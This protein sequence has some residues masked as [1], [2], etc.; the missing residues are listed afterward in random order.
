MANVSQQFMDD[1]GPL[2][3]LW[4]GRDQGLQENTSQ[5]NQQVGLENIANSQQSRDIAKQK[6]PFE[7]GQL[8]HQQQMNPL[9]IQEKEGKIKSDKVKLDKEQFDN[10]FGEF[11]QTIPQLQGTPADGALLGEV[12]KK[13]GMDPQDPRIRRMIDTAASGNAEAVNKMLEKIALADPK[14]KQDMAKEYFS[15]TQQTGRT[16]LTEQGANQRNAAT[17]AGSLQRAQIAAT[18]RAGALK[19]KSDIYALTKGDPVK[20]HAMLVMKAK[21]AQQA[22]DVDRATAL[23]E[24]AN[25]PTLLASVQ[26]QQAQR[27]QTV[28]TTDAQGN[29]TIGSKGGTVPIPQA[30]PSRTVNPGMATAPSSMPPGHEGK[31]GAAPFTDAEKERRYQEWKKS[32]GL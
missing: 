23:Y 17:I 27:A 14:H 30:G 1:M 25:D 18:A 4:A 5:V 24:M 16:L 12:A 29:P 20:M 3:A 15:Q 8:Q 19:D 10:F 6:L 32:Q 13:H 11:R 9:L 31:G 26:N 21:E 28:L 22:G 2:A 7:L